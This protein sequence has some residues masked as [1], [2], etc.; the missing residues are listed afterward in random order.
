MP[1]P[2]TKPL[3][4]GGPDVKVIDQTAN[5]AELLAA[6]AWP[7]I[8][9]WE[10]VDGIPRSHEIDR[11][12][13]A[14]VR[15]PL[16]MLSRQWQLGEFEGD[17]AGSPVF[18]KLH[19]AKTRLTTY[20]A[21]RDPEQPLEDGVPLEARVERRAIPF[22][23]D[24]QPIAL[25][26][27]LL[28]GRHWSKLL[29]KHGLGAYVDGFRRAFRVTP[30]PAPSD[31]SSLVLAHRE[32]WQTR[33][34]FGDRALDGRLW[35]EWLVAHPAPRDFSLLPAPLAVGSADTDKLSD[36][37]DAFIAWFARLIEQPSAGDAWEPDRFEYRFGCSAPTPSGRK[38]LAA[39][40]Y[41]GGHLDWYAFDQGAPSRSAPVRS[42][43][44][45]TETSTFLP[46]P[47]EFNGM[48]NTRYWAFEDRRVSFAGIRPDTT[49]LAKLLLL[50]FG[51]V[52]ANDWC[53]VPV[54]V[55]AGSI[56][57]VLGLAVT[58]VFGERTWIE[59]AA[60]AAG[61]G[62][63]RFRLFGLS[64]APGS[65][66]AA[67][68]SLLMLPTVP[69]IQEGPPLERVALVRDEMANMVWG[70]EATVPLPPGLGRSG[71]GAAAENAEYFRRR[72]S[73]APSTPPLE[74]DAKVRY[75]LM[76]SVPENWIPFVPVHVPGDTREIQLQRA[77]LP[78]VIDNDTGPILRIK[79]L[80][81]LLREGLDADTSAPY[82]VHEEEVPRA[83]A[84]VEQRYQRTRWS[85]GRVFVWLG[86]EKSV[87]RG[88]DSSGL[89]FDRLADVKP[90]T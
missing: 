71:S 74:N 70:I 64:A 65:N 29:V 16:W 11:A 78:R 68:Q 51:L 81:S 45:T 4:L 41:R 27:R 15:D 83:G 24:G 18:A 30:P 8:T 56:V 20:R 25:D 79:P 63:Q 53:V 77:S 13:R 48:A 9:R 40:G 39:E 52:Y 59:P 10:R 14:E 17:D 85:D 33:A 87:G 1:K 43:A 76:T 82:F 54:P 6:R 89:E 50:E 3:E 42:D 12:L 72:R 60:Q 49:D 36:L 86:A 61:A 35:Y 7:S 58:N 67:D 88:E 5:M 2:V 34:A 22:S 21:A 23:C 90:R 69:K 84:V 32:A 37:C 80:T 62:W 26:V 57:E 46:V 38:E 31:T 75:E 28:L 47:V 66:A 44:S 19:L 55:D 73:G